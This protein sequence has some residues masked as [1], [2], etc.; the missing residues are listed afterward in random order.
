MQV[1]VRE[2]LKLLRSAKKVTISHGDLTVCEIDRA[3][4]DS[5]VVDAWGDYVAE[6]IIGIDSGSTYEI[7]LASRPIKRGN[8]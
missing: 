5:I 6:E 1:T 3:D 7:A 4:F 2:A 8:E